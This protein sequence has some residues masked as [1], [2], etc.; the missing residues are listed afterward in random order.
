MLNERQTGR[1]SL[2]SVLS[3]YWNSFVWILIIF[4]IAW[5]TLFALSYDFAKA[6]H[7]LPRGVY[8]FRSDESG[9]T[10]F[11]SGAELAVALLFVKDYAIY[12]LPTVALL[13]IMFVLIADGK[14]NLKMTITRW[15][16]QKVEEEHMAE[17]RAEGS[18]RTHAA[19]LEWY[20]R[21]QE[22]R[23]KREPFDEPPPEM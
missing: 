1:V 21:F 18:A 9:A 12:T 22:A 13:A 15:L 3:K 20:N 2:W 8:T 7:S 4:L 19:W 23:K 14:E 6:S 10:P 16:R 17:A 11:K 5:T